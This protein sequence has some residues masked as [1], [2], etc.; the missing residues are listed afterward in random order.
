M[1]RGRGT[2][3]AGEMCGRVGGCMGGM[4]C[5]AGVIHGTG[6]MCGRGHVSQ[7]MCVAG[8]AC[9]GGGEGGRACVAGETATAA[10]STH[11]TGMH[12]CDTVLFQLPLSGNFCVCRRCGS[13]AGR[14]E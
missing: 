10:N 5:M 3:V 4:A 9:V 1:A 13:D 14:P 2:C 12:S 7:G 11:P 6:G 8:E